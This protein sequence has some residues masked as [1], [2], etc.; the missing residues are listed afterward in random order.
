[1]PGTER[2]YPE[3]VQKYRTRGMTVKKKD[4]S[5]YLYQRTSRRVRGKKYPQPV[6]HYV[7]VITPDGILYAKSR[8]APK[9]PRI[10]VREY[11]WTWALL[12]KCPASW[13]RL[14]GG[15]WEDILKDLVIQHSPNTYLLDDK[16]RRTEP[17]QDGR[18]DDLYAALGRAMKECCGVDMAGLE[19]LKYV[20]ILE[21]LDTGDTAFSALDA[22]QQSLL[23]KLSLHLPE[24]GADCSEPPV[25][26]RTDVL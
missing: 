8:I 10:R 22:W 26:P 25:Q 21:D 23:E 16:K 9:H 13:K 15:H 7:G 18:L 11:G 12:E 17:G 20:Y 5:Y 19:P 2:T 4:N 1:M 6:D 14:A 3:W 24:D